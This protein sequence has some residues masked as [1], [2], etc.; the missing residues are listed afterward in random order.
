MELFL[1]TETTG[2]SHDK[3]RIV[4]ITIVDQR[5]RALMDTLVNPDRRIPYYASEV[6]GI[7]DDMVRD[8]PNIYSLMPEIK[9]MVEGNDVIA[10]NAPFD[11][12]FF[13]NKLKNAASISCAMRVFA[14]FHGSKKPLKLSVAADIVGH[15]WSGVAHRALAD[16]LACKSVWDAT[17]DA[18]KSGL[19]QSLVKSS[20]KA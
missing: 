2:F 17:A 6:H 1:D 8:M 10:Y 20:S 11:V 19:I 5:G 9:K 4:E 18:R 7:T 3:D 16:T 15:V 14:E 12:G 13:P